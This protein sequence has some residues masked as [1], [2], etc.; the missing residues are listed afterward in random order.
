MG[1]SVGWWN[2]KNFKCEDCIYCAPWKLTQEDGIPR[3]SCRRHAPRRFGFPNVRRLE[4]WC[5]EF[6]R[7]EKTPDGK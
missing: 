6:S 7:K 4:D 1:E 3:G 2:L 5:G